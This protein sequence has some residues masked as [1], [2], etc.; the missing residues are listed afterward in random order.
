M[1]Y[2]KTNAEPTTITRDLRTLDE[3]SGN[4]YETIAILGKRANQIGMDIKE[5]LSG[6]LQE[7]ATHTDNLEEIFENREQIEISKFY[8]KLPKPSDI[9]SQEFM[10]DKI[11]FRNPLTEN[12][13][14]NQ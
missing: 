9:A 8:E 4:V 5:E 7:F 13:Q 14:E 11:Y 3:T 12:G 10:E 2:K 1:D 6:K